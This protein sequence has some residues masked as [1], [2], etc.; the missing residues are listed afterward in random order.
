M[1]RGAPGHIYR[2]RGWVGA[3]ITE[4]TRENRDNNRTTPV[5]KAKIPA[6]PC[7]LTTPATQAKASSVKIPPLLP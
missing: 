3:E 5:W 7:S 1:A 2:M 6:A 4:D